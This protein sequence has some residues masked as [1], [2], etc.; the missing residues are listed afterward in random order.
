M[1]W[2]AFKVGM[3][4]HKLQIPFPITFAS[5]D[6]ALTQPGRPG[7]GGARGRSASGSR[8]SKKSD[9]GS[10]GDSSEVSKGDHLTSAQCNLFN[11]YQRA[12]MNTL[13]NYPQFLV[14]LVLGGLKNP[15]VTALGGLLWLAGR[16]VYCRGYFTGEPKNR[17]K[18]SFHYT[19][20][21]IC[22]LTTM[23]FGWS[24]LRASPY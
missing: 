16:V 21:M 18:G 13:E 8:K 4:R 1:F 10:G 5:R 19:G 24:L 2:L 17:I 12:H 23:N 6:L 9:D 22:L 11:C 14:L 15:I 3:L 20:L 7:R